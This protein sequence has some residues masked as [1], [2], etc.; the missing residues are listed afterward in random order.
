[1]ILY[2]LDMQPEPTTEKISFKDKVMLIGSCFSEHIAKSLSQLYFDVPSQ[3]LGIVFNP[4]SLARPF[5]MMTENKQFLEADLVSSHDTWYSKFHHG[6]FSDS[7]KE[8][9]LKNINQAQD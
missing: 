2:N 1:M 9:L 8:A 7:K 4:V 5:S 3:P 6:I